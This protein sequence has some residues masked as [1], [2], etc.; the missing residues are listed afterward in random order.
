MCARRVPHI[1]I[2]RGR[3]Y[4]RNE[5][6]EAI[7]AAYRADV[8]QNGAREYVNV[9]DGSVFVEDASEYEEIICTVLSGKLASLR[10]DEMVLTCD[11]FRHL[12]IECCETCHTFYPH[13]EM[14]LIHVGSVGE[15][16]LCCALGAVLKPERA[17]K[18]LE[19]DD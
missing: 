7:L 1:E 2:G 16:W 15:A 9:N 14:D 10:P 17:K 5:I 12:G 13:D 8:A 6:T 19:S 3:M 11:D 4:T 18:F